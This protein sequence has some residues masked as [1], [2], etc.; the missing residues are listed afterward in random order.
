MHMCMYTRSHGPRREGF[1]NVSIMS[2]TAK[3]ASAFYG[4]FRDALASAPK[5]GQKHRIIPPNKKTY[6]MD[7]GAGCWVVHWGTRACVPGEEGGSGAGLAYCGG[8]VCFS[9]CGPLGQACAPLTLV[10]GTYIRG[11]SQ[12]QPTMG[13]PLSDMTFPLLAHSHDQPTNRRRELPRG[14]ARDPRGRGRGR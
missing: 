4:P 10:G 7:P 12:M 3:Y 6:Q 11:S 1:T 2:Y 14:P 5:P 8:R 13:S 9:L